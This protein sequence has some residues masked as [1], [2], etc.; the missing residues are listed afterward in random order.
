MNT[1]QMLQ[2]MQ[3]THKN[4]KNSL[5]ELEKLKLICSTEAGTETDKKNFEKL[6]EKTKK[7]FI[8]LKT[9]Y[10]FLSR[11]KISLP[12]EFS[13]IKIEIDKLEERLKKI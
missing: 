1:I 9:F 8:S 12:S 11:Q 2:Q 10:N 5:D 3:K 7:S 13:E 6:Q 4:V